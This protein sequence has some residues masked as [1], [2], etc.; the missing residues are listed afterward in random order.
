[1]EDR[2]TRQEARCAMQGALKKI[3][4]PYLRERGFKGSFPYLRRDH[5]GVLDL[6]SVQFDQHGGGFLLEISACPAEA[7][8]T[9]WGEEIPP[10]KMTAEYL[11]IDQR[12][13]LGTTKWNNTP[14]LRYDGSASSDIFE[15]LAARARDL[16]RN[17]AEGWWAHNGHRFA[18]LNDAT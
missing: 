4:L 3:L 15:V 6:L 13:R 8:V 2:L 14:W 5:N 17:E 11:P 12:H 1:M 7:F 9:K 16:V 18:R 10:S